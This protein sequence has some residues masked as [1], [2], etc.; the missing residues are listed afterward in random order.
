MSLVPTGAPRDAAI[1]I[2]PFKPARPGYGPVLSY[3]QAAQLTTPL[4]I[5]PL[6]QLRTWDPKPYPKYLAWNAIE[7]PMFAAIWVDFDGI[8]E[9]GQPATSPIVEELNLGHVETGWAIRVRNRMVRTFS[10]N[11]RLKLNVLRKGITCEDVLFAIYDF[12]ASPLYVDELGEM[13]PRA[14]RIMEQQYFEKRR[15]GFFD[16][17]EGY[18]KSDA[19]LGATYFDG[20]HNDP[21]SVERLKNKYNFHSSNFLL[22]RLGNC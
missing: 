21:E 2:G 11:L 1:T 3:L 12:F 9:R 13:H 15:M 8:K 6:L 22:L 17:M 7:H 20:I 5:H 18:R 19:L 10:V 14:V 4:K 16:L